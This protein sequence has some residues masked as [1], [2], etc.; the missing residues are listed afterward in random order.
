[1]LIM[2]LVR[3]LLSNTSSL[4]GEESSAPGEAPRLAP[5]EAPGE[6]RHLQAKENQRAVHQRGQETGEF[7]WK[8]GSRSL[9]PRA[10]PVYRPP[11]SPSPLGGVSASGS[12]PGR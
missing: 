7:T 10:L 8:H 2:N 5:Q 4:P 6:K 9:G 11:R 12:G 1:M 3:P